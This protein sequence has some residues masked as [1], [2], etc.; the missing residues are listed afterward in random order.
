[1]GGTYEQQA[2]LAECVRV[3]QVRLAYLTGVVAQSEWFGHHITAK[4]ITEAIAYV[5][6]EPRIASLTTSA[7]ETPALAHAAWQLPP[8]PR[9]A[10][11]RVKMEWDVP[12]KEL[13]R[14][15][16]AAVK[17]GDG[18]AAEI[19][20]TRAWVFDGMKWNLELQ[21]ENDEDDG[22]VTFGLFVTPSPP[23]GH[24][25]GA[26]AAALVSA[27][28]SLD[29]RST[30][31]KLRAGGTMTMLLGREGRGF[32]DMLELGGLKEWDEGALRD[33]GLVGDDDTVRVIASVRE[34]S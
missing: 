7:V 17:E 32:L 11:R 2:G 6:A 3:P 13:K 27:R 34:V 21:A 12:L 30:Y 9:S 31:G 5:L 25:S 33:A 4:E 19:A 16:K 8:R 18:G 20:S 1:M 10:V 22:G 24:P 23:P 15:H 14:L 29:A 28:L 26:R